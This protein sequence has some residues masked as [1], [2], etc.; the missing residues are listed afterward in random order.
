V[1]VAVSAPVGSDPLVPRAPVQPFDAVQAVALVLDQARVALPPLATVEGAADRL[2]VG[3]PATVTV[4]DLV[5]VPPGPVQASVKFV[6]V[7]RAGVVSVPLAAFEPLQ[8]PLAEQLVA[9]LL[10]HDSVDAAPDAIEVGAALKLTAGAD[11]TTTVADCDTVPPAPVQ[12]R[13]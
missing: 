12:L 2:T 3:G 5:V 9:P 11:G 8:P 7:A 4:S 6:L 1:R 10:D 13:V